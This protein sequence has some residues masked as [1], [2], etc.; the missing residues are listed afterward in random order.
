MNGSISV[1]H[2]K[3]NLESILFYKVVEGILFY[4]AVHDTQGHTHP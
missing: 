3:E 1:K 4:K 2:I